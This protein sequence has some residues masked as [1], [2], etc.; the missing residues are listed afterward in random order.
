MRHDSRRFWTQDIV[1]RG[2]LGMVIPI[3]ICL[4]LENILSTFIQ[5]GQRSLVGFIRAGVIDLYHRAGRT[6][7]HMTFHAAG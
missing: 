3:G 4:E 1:S 2:K 5:D 6:D 7:G